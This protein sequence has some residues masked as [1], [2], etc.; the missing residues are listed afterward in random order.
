MARKILFVFYLLMILLGVC[1]LVYNIFFFQGEEP[2]FQNRSLI[3]VII[4]FFYGIIRMKNPSSPKKSLS[5]YEK[6]YENEIKNAFCDDKKNRKKLLKALQNYNVDKYEKSIQQLNELVPLCKNSQ[7]RY[8]VN[9]FLAKNYTDLEDS[10][11]AISIYESMI[12]TG[13]AD[14][15]VFSNLSLFYIELG[16][17]EKA[18]KVCKMAI[19]FDSKNE[20]AYHNL[21]S[22]YFRLG[23]YE[24]GI[25]YSQEALKINNKFAHSLK[26]LA[27]IYYILGDTEQG[28]NYKKRAIACGIQKKDIENSINYFLG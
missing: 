14:S 26:L 22:V 10:V 5:Y 15:T 8:A 7:E 6:F 16:D 17:L 28:E 9:F 25:T 11:N 19:Q 20:Y 27:I 12:Q 1:G 4:A 3:T 2:L 21:A 23:E 13:I 24:N 18:Q